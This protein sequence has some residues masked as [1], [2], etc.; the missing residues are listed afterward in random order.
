ML[1]QAFERIDRY[2]VTSLE[3]W[4]IEKTSAV[5][6]PRPPH[7]VAVLMDAVPIDESSLADRYFLK[8]M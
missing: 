5:C 4:L 8:G 3:T 6:S 2:L 7:P 1:H